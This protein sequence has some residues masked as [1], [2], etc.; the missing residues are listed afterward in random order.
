MSFRVELPPTFAQRLADQ[1]SAGQ[2]SVGA[3]PAGLGSAEPGR[4][5]SRATASQATGGRALVGMWVTSG[6][7]VNTEIAAGSGL[8]WILI[9]GEHAPLSLADIQSQLQVV[10]AYPATPVVRVPANDVVLI[11]QYLDLG[12]Q[13]LLVPMVHTPEDAQAAVRATRYPPQGVRGVG[14]ALARGARWNRVANYLQRANDELVSLIVQIESAQ[15]VDNAEEI[16]ATDGVDAIFIGPS[17]LAASMGLIGQQ[18]HP[19][20]VANVQRAIAAARKAGKPVGINAF[21]PTLANRYI[22]EGID[23]ILVGADVAILARQSEALADTYIYAR[24]GQA[25][26]E[27]PDSY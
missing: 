15:A 2:P 10:A 26:G 21:D 22:D 23:F 16:A 19:D 18:G 13:N 5:D 4:A 11:K 8:D 6:S 27:V 7:L 12:A 9:D 17:D 3:G 20:V 1:R 24:Q 25:G 14:S